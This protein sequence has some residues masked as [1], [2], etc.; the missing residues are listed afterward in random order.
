MVSLFLL[1]VVTTQP[2]PEALKLGRQLAESGTL[3]TLLPIMQEKETEDLIKAHPELTVN[4]KTALRVTSQRVFETGRARLMA[5][6]AQSYAKRMN[7]GDLRAAAAFQASAAGKRYRAVT[8][9]I[10]QDVMPAMAGMDFKKDVAT[11]FCR[12]TGKLCGK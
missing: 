6:E 2:S 8:P 1:A 12:E 3:A 5:A 11:A 10:I 9:D 7:I 4:E